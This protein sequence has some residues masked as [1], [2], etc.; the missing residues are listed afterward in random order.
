MQI[1]FNKYKQKGEI[2]KKIIGL[3][4][5]HE[6]GKS[7]ISLK[8]I[9]NLRN[10]QMLAFWQPFSFEVKKIC[11]QI[12]QI[13]QIEILPYYTQKGKNE[14]LKNSSMTRRKFIEEVT[15]LGFRIN[16]TFWWE[17][18]TTYV[19]TTMPSCFIIVDD[20][21]YIDSIPYLNGGPLIYINNPNITIPE[22]KV[23]KY[24]ELK[25]KSSYIYTNNMSNNPEEFNKL[26]S[27]IVNY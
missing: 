5:Y 19:N 4:G 27:Y 9:E 6:T 21:N 17:R 23:S 2:M 7:Y 14:L 8:I 20:V 1:I 10:E 26:M 24:A 22:S 15:E 12:E 25:N 13:E 11:A 18:W 3:C 16:K